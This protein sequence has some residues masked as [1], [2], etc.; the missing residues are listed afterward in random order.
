MKISLAANHG[1]I[2][3]GEVMLLAMAESARQLGHDVT[4]VAPSGKL[5]DEAQ[6]ANHRTVVINTESALGYLRGLR[7]WASRARTGLLW[8]NGLRPALATSGLSNRVVHLHSLPQG[9]MATAAQVAARGARRVVVPSEWMQAQL[10]INSTVLHN[11]TRELPFRPAE[12]TLRQNADVRLG[13]FG[14]LTID[15]G[16]LVLAEAVRQLNQR[17]ETTFRLVIGGEPRFSTNRDAELIQTALTS[18]NPPVE[19]LGW[20][21]PATFFESVDIAAFPSVAPESFGLVAAE[22][23]AFGRPFVTSDAGALP[24]VSEHPRE[25][26]A[27][28]GDAT[29]I[30]DSIART[31]ARADRDTLVRA[32]T[33][34]EEHFSPQAGTARFEGLIDSLEAAS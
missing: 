17:G 26:I 28:A 23:M 16:A 8:C 33:R 4:V 32:R 29:S 31:V 3:G 27:A 15:K 22:A 9:A 10:S 13:F 24:E 30:A 2:G 18:L 7:R 25:A 14:R 34:W 12:T 11:W 6:T 20:T 1:E 5:I 19:H 21:E